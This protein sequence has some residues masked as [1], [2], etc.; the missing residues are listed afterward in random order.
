MTEQAVAFVEGWI[1]DNLTSEA[2]LQFGSDPRAQELGQ[3]AIGAAEIAGIP[4]SDVLEEF[5]DLTLNVSQAIDAAAD[6][7][8][9]YQIDN[10]G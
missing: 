6:T 5:P 9:Q 4:T 7:E 2:L 8:V 3:A 1:A 10:D